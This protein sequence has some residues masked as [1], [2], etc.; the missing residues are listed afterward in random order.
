MKVASTSKGTKPVTKHENVHCDWFILPLLLPTP[1]MW[2][3]LDHKLIVSDGV[4]SGVGKNGHKR[5]YDSNYD[6]DSDS[7][8]SENIKLFG[9]V[10]YR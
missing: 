2:F 1:I 6:A 3:S 10:I 8:A 4:V 5:S 9:V 7:V